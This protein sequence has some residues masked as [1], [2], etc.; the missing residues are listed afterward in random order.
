[1]Q[2]GDKLMRVPHWTTEF[3]PDEYRGEQSCEVI[4]I[5]AKHHH[6]TVRYIKSGQTETFKEVG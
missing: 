4:A 3:I 2:V 5:N 6:Y 1:M